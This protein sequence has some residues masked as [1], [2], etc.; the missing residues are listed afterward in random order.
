[1]VDDGEREIHG[2]A[3]T[4]L[5]GSAAEAQG[6][7]RRLGF[8]EEGRALQVLDRLA[9]PTR[10]L[11][12]LP[13]DLL[14]AA[15]Q[16]GS[17]DR[18]LRGL[19]R[20]VDGSGMSL[21]LY[22]RCRDDPAL[23]QSLARVL[24]HST[25]LTDILVRSPEYLYWLFEET[26]FL[27]DPLPKNTLRQIL[28]Q[29]LQAASSPEDRLDGLR[30][31]QRRELLRIGAA[32]I[33]GLRQVEEAGRELANLADVVLEIVLDVATKELVDR[34]GQPLDERGRPARFCIVCLGKQGGRELNFSSDIDLM[35]AYDEDG[36][37]RPGRTGTAA[38]NHAFFHRLGERVVQAL[39]TTTPEGALY[40]V[41]MRL[42]P[43]GER[44]P[45]VRSLRSYWIY[46]ETRGELWER[47][48]LIKAR[49]AAGSTRLW[50]RLQE[51]LIPFTYP[52][53]FSV[54]PQEEIRRIKERIETRIF[55][56]PAGGNN[57]KLQAGGIRDIEFIVQCLQL[58]NGRINP[59]ARAQGTLEAIARLAQAEVLQ[60]D[61][62]DD[63]RG[64]YLFLRRL[65][66][67]LQIR[68]GRSAYAMPERPEEQ[69]S[70]A[71]NM[72]QSGAEALRG[73][74][75]GHFTRVKARF[76]DLFRGQEREA[77]TL[78]WLL[79]AESGGA[80]AAAVLAEYGF[81]DG[82]AS[83]RILSQLG[84]ADT[85]MTSGRQRLAALVPEL[86]ASLAAAPDP[87]QGLL[88]FAQIAEAYGAP[89]M[90]Y[91]LLGLNSGFRK[92]LIT[93]CGASHFLAD[94]I[95]RDPGLL[96]GLANRDTAGAVAEFVGAHGDVGAVRR[97]RNQELLRIGTDDLL[98]LTSSEETFLRL[99]ELAEEV[100]DRV[101]REAWRQLVR[102]HGKPRT[103]GG[104]E[105]RFS[106]WA[107][108]K[109]GGREMDFGSDLDLFFVYEAEGRTGRTRTDNRVFF[110]ELCQ[111]ILSLLQGHGLYRVDVRL[112]P[113]GRSAPMAISLAA[114]RRYLA[115]RAATWERLALTRARMVA[116][117]PALGDRVGRAIQRFVTGAPV[118]SGFAA[119]IRVLR[120][121]ME[122]RRGRGRPLPVD[123]KRGSGGLVDIE[124][125]AQI[126]VLTLGRRY[127]EMRSTSTRQVLAQYAEI[128]QVYSAEVGFLLQAYDELRE[129]E[130]GMRM[131]S[132]QASSILPGGREL[133]VLARLAGKPDPDC[134]VEDLKSLM[135]ET[136]RV[137]DR[138]LT[139]LTDG[140]SAHG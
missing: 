58:L 101:Y 8:A 89:G 67:L 126:L 43:E 100:L 118:D 96:D 47:Q 9:D 44:G 116:G 121:R 35:F 40:R 54:S 88:R 4:A 11:A 134:L 94:L 131:A 105:A 38:D 19:E 56:R 137:F 71:A 3:R 46:Y 74:L 32:E 132:E 6:A 83:H 72:G 28:S 49:R 30:R 113:E 16:S 87:D 59:L 18:A 51:V 17:P 85:M 81:S 138:L 133:R 139:A 14:V 61:E 99:T 110:I 124:F 104:R 117:D 109:F 29:D 103:R 120:R 1:M 62:A 114:Y 82:A 15:A 48:M 93:I 70:L 129:L 23:G 107:A 12:P 69:E 90:L 22:S 20:F 33:L 97:Y 111:E 75:N 31:S 63:L 66:S 13:L 37:T 25:F 27:R 60:A 135:R 95:H 92:V 39:T 98:G 127:R 26:P 68:E 119:E 84:S 41:D 106:C 122:P 112:R 102:R 78:E 2:L 123:I 53:H 24:G 34:H 57:I 115:Q 7:L 73:E 91:E 86:V 125:I 140:G 79:D 64:A 65:E 10:T 55:E 80:R 52:A 130:K 108:G 5:G 50:R 36:R 136:R 21:S 45:L 128:Q 42:R 76:D 77:Q